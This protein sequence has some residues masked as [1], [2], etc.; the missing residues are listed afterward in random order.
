MIN[1]GLGEPTRANGFE[2]PA[3]INASIID[4]INGEKNNGYCQSTGTAEARAA[5]AE[6]FGTE[7]HPI[8]KNHIFFSFGCS[9]ALYN[10]I[11]VMCEVGD[12]ILVPKP[13]FPLCQPICQNLGVEFDAYNLL[14]EEGWKIDLANLRSQITPKTRAILVNNPSNPCGS[15]FTA[16][17][18][19]EILAVAEEFKLPIIADEVYYG[20]SYNPERP[21]VSFGN[22]TSTVP[23]VC[24]GAISKIYCLPG[25]RCGWTIFYNNGGYFDDVLTRMSMHSMIQLHPNSLVMAALPKILKE[26]PESHFDGMR[27]K[28]STV[29]AA[30][31]ER[32]STIRGVTPI[33]SSAAMYMMVRIDYAE[34]HDIENDVAFCSK[35]LN[36]Q[37]CLTFPSKCFFEDGFFRMI[38]CTTTEVINEFGD[39]LQE[40]CDAHYKA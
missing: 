14:P 29:S 18:M 2:L 1:L 32:L 3:V 35:L 19:Q 34:F 16:E 22:A 36:E 5:V 13:G 8:D 20:L 24:T 7:E 39:R 21:F 6:K 17:H 31:F 37:N 30:A 25:W 10:A 28:L 9:G 38:I 11:S 4:V 40:F 15:C 26:V 27:Q 33:R 12:R 23:V